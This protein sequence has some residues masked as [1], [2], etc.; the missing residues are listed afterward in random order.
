LVLK[1]LVRS[2][3]STNDEALE[4]E[5]PF[6]NDPND[7]PLD[8]LADLMQ[9]EVEYFSNISIPWSTDWVMPGL[10]GNPIMGSKDGLQADFG[11]P[12]ATGPVDAQGVPLS[13]L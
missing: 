9:D 11:T 13:N 3:V 1:P 2:F 6:G 12:F 8:D 4:V 10:V 7:L 5:N